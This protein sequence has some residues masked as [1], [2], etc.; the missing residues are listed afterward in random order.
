[1]PPPAS[2]DPVV[3]AP[4]PGFWASLR[5]ARVGLYPLLALWALELGNG[6]SQSTL[7][8]LGPEIA[9]ALGVGLPFIALVTTVQGHSETV[10]SFLVAGLVQR[11]PW[12]ARVAKLGALT[13]SVASL[14]VGLVPNA[15]ALAGYGL[16]D[17]ATSS[18]VST[19]HSPLLV[20]VYPG[21]V[22][23][24][25]LSLQTGLTQAVAVLP[26]VFVAVVTGL[27]GLGWRAVFVVTGVASIAL[28]LAAR[29]LRDPGFT[30]PGGARRSVGRA[31]QVAQFLGVLRHLVSMPTGRRMLLFMFLLGGTAFIGT[32][33]N[34]EFAQRQHLTPA[35][36]AILQAFPSVLPIV[37]P[38]LLG[39][40]I[41]R[42][43]RAGVGRPFVLAALMELAGL[44][45][46]A[47]LF[48]VPVL[49]LAIGA[50]VA[51]GLVE[52]VV[53]PARTAAFFSVLPSAMRPHALAAL[54]G[55]AALGG[56]LGLAETTLSTRLGLVT[57]GLISLALPALGA[58]VLA[59][60]GWTADADARALEDEGAAT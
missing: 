40:F 59:S 4:I 55:M 42:L 26:F 14:G 49:W 36:R 44:G 53:V 30:T 29:G 24:R 6:L 9:R 10:A 19:L 39:P 11:R 38:V 8:V 51:V 58:L 20:D 22:R 57:T 5:S 46:V 48:L 16:I 41:E 21:S 31:G 28:C 12:R 54:G 18:T 34:F 35:A 15:A 3:E 17:G 33:L 43:L 60:A 37:A 2:S 45:L 23:A 50:L 25:I 27:F 47:L 13:W 52:V 56:L 1:M 7:I 32:Y